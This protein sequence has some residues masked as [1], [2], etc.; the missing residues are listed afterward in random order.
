MDELLRISVRCALDNT[1]FK[2]ALKDYRKLLPIVAPSLVARC[3]H[4]KKQRA[5]AYAM[6][7][8]VWNRVPRPDY[9]WQPRPL[10]RN[11]MA[12]APAARAKKTSNA[13]GPWPARRLWAAKV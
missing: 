5:L 11:A 9:D 12:P 4:S 7:R 1:D 3:R 13:A 2:A 10:R 6:F 8:E